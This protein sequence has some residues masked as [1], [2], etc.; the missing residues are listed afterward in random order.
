MIASE[1]REMFGESSRLAAAIESF[2]DRP[3]VVIASGVANPRFGEAAE[4]YQRYRANESRALAAR[5]TRG[6]FVL[7]AET[8]HRLHEEAADRVLAS[9]RSVLAEASNRWRPLLRRP[10]GSRPRATLQRLPGYSRRAASRI[11]IARVRSS[12]FST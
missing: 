11:L 9:I 2:G 8:T 5:S 12:Q 6:A 10:A 4:A 7:A 3:L 1:H